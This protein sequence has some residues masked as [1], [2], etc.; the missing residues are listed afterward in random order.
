[1]QFQ[2]LKQIEESVFYLEIN[3]FLKTAKTAQTS[4]PELEILE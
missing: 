3:Y 4:F 2:V 1:M